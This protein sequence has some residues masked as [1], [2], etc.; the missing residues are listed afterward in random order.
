MNK[1]IDV[2][3]ALLA[4]AGLSFVGYSLYKEYNDFDYSFN[5][6]Y[7]PI[8][9]KDLSAEVAQV[10]VDNAKDY[11]QVT[12]SD[13]ITR[14]DYNEL[15]EY[16]NTVYNKEGIRSISTFKK[17]C[18]VYVAILVNT[19]SGIGIQKAADLIVKEDSYALA[20]RI[21]KLMGYAD[22]KEVEKY[23]NLNNRGMS[24]R[25]KKFFS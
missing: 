9:D 8:E 3:V 4:I 12:G 5:R 19:E 11:F 7:T 10:L 22:A 6:I 25:I 18:A 21:T 14:D 15:V 1:L 24:Y 23:V 2:V 16:C 17:F 13:S 20:E